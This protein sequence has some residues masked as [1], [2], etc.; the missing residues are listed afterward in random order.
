MSVHYR[1]HFVEPTLADPV[2]IQTSCLIRF[3]SMSTWFYS[4]EPKNYA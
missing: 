2:L 1:V 3:L 4:R